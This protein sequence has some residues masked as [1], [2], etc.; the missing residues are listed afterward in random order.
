MYVKELTS[1]YLCSPHSLHGY[2][3]VERSIPVSKNILQRNTSV[4]E[5]LEQVH[6]MWLISVTL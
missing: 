3:L 2:L 6:F 4:G 5:I 1:L